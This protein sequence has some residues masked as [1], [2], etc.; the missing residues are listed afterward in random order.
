MG[1]AS[2]VIEAQPLLGADRAQRS[3]SVRMNND[4]VRRGLGRSK[5]QRHRR[6]SWLWRGAGARSYRCRR[7]RSVWF[8]VISMPTHATCAHSIKTSDRCTTIAHMQSEIGY[9]QVLALVLEELK[10]LPKGP[11]RGAKRG[12]SPLGCSQGVDL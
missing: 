9:Q 2:F 10:A 7:R 4:T 1:R 8:Q 6:A 12:G 5:R 11:V 3:G